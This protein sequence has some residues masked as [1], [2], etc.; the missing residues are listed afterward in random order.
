[1]AGRRGR[2]RSTAQPGRSNGVREPLKQRS[3]R[4]RGL[5][6][7]G[8]LPRR[9]HQ[10][11]PRRRG[12]ADRGRRRDRR[13]RHR[14][15]RLRQPPAAAARR[16]PR[17][18]G[19]ARGSPRRRDR[20]GQDLRRAQPVRRGHAARPAG[21]AVPGDDPRGLAQGGLRLRRGHQ[22]GGLHAPLR[23]DQAAH[24]DAAAVQEPRQR[25]HL[26]LRARALPAAPGGGGRRLHP[27]RDRCD[28]ADRRRGQGRRRP[29]RR[30]G[31]RQ[32]RRA[33]RRTS[34]PAPTSRRRR[35]CSPRAAG[36]I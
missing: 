32:G 6:A 7:P 3:G 36:A 24:P 8:R 33:A 11:R 25:G 27:H 30:Q 14:R 18:D 21:R 15:P 5:P 9:V 20:E 13:R 34:S 4:T 19:A 10:A 26:G 22:G 23:Q 17:D 1:M 31:A 16:R 35:R 29:L 28:A 12:R 2:Q